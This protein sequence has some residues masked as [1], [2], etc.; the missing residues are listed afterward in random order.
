HLVGESLIGWI[1]W[2]LSRC[3][4]VLL[5]RPGVDKDKIILL[6]SVAGGGDPAGVT[7]AVDPRIACVVPFNF[8]GPQPETSFPLADDAEAAFTYAGSGS[9]ESTRDLRLSARDGFMPWV[10]VGSVAP[11]RVIHAH[12][13]AWDK[14]RDPVWKRYQKIFAWYNAADNVDASKGRGS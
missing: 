9:W 11:R 6:G 5:S 12:E 1:S 4:D 2:D 14:E 8:G 7:A 13:F 10:I 3:V